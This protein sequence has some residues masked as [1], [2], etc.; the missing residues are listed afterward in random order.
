MNDTNYKS[1]LSILEEEWDLLTP[2]EKSLC[3]TYRRLLRANKKASQ[4][5]IIEINLIHEKYPD[6]HLGCMPSDYE[7]K[8]QEGDVSA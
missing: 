6:F 1:P 4:T 3:V 2:G 8:M 5:L 7:I